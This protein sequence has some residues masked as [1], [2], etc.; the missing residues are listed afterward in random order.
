VSATPQTVNG[1]FFTNSNSKL[2]MYSPTIMV[3]GRNKITWYRSSKY[4]ITDQN[5]KINT[6]ISYYSYW[7]SKLLHSG[8]FTALLGFGKL[9]SRILVPQRAVMSLCGT[10]HRNQYSYAEVN[11]PRIAGMVSMS[12]M[13]R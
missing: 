3:M 13:V 10:S 6:F 8:N 2:G 5:V 4:V 12:V 1:F 7:Y 11:H 9:K